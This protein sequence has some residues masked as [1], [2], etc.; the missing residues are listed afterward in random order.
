M[1][2]T[3][4]KQEPAERITYDD[5]EPGE[6]YY[7]S[8]Q[9]DPDGDAELDG[10]PMIFTENGGLVGLEGG[11]YYPSDYGS[12]GVALQEWKYV[13]VSEAELYVPDAS[14]VE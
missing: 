2:I 14:D 6:V 5:L 7:T 4:G 12:T 13:H 1:R 11:V 8:G 3:N 10:E 9:P